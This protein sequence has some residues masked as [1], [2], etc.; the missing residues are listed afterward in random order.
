ME[1]TTTAPILNTLFTG[2]LVIFGI[3][4]YLF[5][6]IRSRTLLIRS[7]DP[8]IDQLRRFFKDLKPYAIGLYV[9]LYVSALYAAK[10]WVFLYY[11]IYGI[12]CLSLMSS[13]L[14][15]RHV[16]RVKSLKKTPYPK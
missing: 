1:I 6:W 8:L 16:H 13:V 10:Y 2:S 3:D 11:L 7:H 5:S 15:V 4:T 14:I 9:A 12:Q